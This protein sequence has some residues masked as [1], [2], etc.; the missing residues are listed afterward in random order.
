[1][2]WTT[3][4]MVMVRATSDRLTPNS[5]DMLSTAGKY[6]FDDSGEKE[7]AREARITRF[8]FCFLDMT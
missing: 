2:P 3:M 7:P 1:M 6:M 5:A 8:H 4:Y